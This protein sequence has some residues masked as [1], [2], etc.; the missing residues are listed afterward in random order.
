MRNLCSRVSLAEEA[1]PY[2]NHQGGKEIPP[3]ECSDVQEEIGSQV[4]V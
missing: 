4:E 2:H 3:S 1:L